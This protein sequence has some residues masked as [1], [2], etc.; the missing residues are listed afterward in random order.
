MRLRHDGLTWRELDGEAVILNLTT[1]TY[2]STNGVGVFLL[3]LLQ[4]DRSA[5]A[6]VAALLTEYEI[7][8]DTATRDAE[9]FVASLDAQGLLE[10]P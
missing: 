2:L 7:D 9:A 10:H 8:A 5:D 3:R 1:S 4:E 6:L